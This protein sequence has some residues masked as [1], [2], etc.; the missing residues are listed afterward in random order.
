MPFFLCK[1][2]NKSHFGIKTEIHVVVNIVRNNKKG[3]FC[4]SL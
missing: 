1:R 2:I 3:Y 4:L